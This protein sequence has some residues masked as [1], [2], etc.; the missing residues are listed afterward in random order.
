MKKKSVIIDINLEI[1]VGNVSDDKAIEI[2]ENYELP[3]GY[4]ENS[5]KIVKIIKK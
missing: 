4:V 5:F 1:P 2:A 3:H